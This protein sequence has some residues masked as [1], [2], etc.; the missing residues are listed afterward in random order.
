MKARR[1]FARVV[2]GAAV[3]A[4]SWW[5]S[6]ALAQQKGVAGPGGYPVKPIRVING[7]PA[8]SGS[9]V[10]MRSVAQNLGERLG[11]SVIVDNRP[12]ATGGIALQLA[13][14]ALPD[15]YTLATLSA[16][17]VTA[18][19]L[20]TVKIDIQRELTAVV[21]MIGQPYLMVATP[22]L[23]ASSVKELIALAKAR[24]LV[25]ASSGTGSVVHLGMELFKS[26][27]GVEM[28]HV[29]YKGSGLSM[30]DVMSGRVQLAITNVLTA[31]PLVRSGRL[32]ALAITS[33][34]RVQA[35]PD[36]PTV[37]EAGVPGY[38][39]RSWYGLLAPNRTPAPVLAHL[40]REV[41][42]TMNSSEV[43][44]K[45]SA[46]GAEAAAP[47]TPAQFRAVIARE[48]AKWDK[49]IKTGVIKTQ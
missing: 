19:L 39:L 26:M 1:E 11:Q 44:E 33:D 10:M 29:P 31:T 4:V 5:A 17:N 38:E 41:S 7:S 48:I 32:K 12:G 36:L 42:E 21:L 23:P 27:A 13:A 6:D 35:F 9:D 2:A 47:N 24:P 46:D 18:M 16:Q 40:N 45:L 37:A 3:I 25:Y 30:I 43:R 20:G 22:S 28:T 8:G 34:K 15:G 49:L 14:Q